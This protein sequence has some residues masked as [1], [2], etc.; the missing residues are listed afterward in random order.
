MIVGR[1]EDENEI[2]RVYNISRIGLSR[3]KSLHPRL[4]SGCAE[5]FARRSA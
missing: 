3:V 5:T 1:G 4:L 2:A